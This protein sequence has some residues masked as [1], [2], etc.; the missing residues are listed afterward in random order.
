MPPPPY[1]PLCG[2]KARELGI[3]HN[4]ME[5]FVAMDIISG[6]TSSVSDGRT[7]SEDEGTYSAAAGEVATS[8]ASSSLARYGQVMDIGG[9][10]EWLYARQD[11]AHSED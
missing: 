3:I 4:L 10:I 9:F 8:G 2:A 6:A 5:S 11:L 7:V 1:P